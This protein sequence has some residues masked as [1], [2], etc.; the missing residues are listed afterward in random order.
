M[1]KIKHLLSKEDLDLI[2]PYL[3]FMVLDNE[4]KDYIKL[5]KSQFG[6]KRRRLWMFSSLLALIIILAL[7]FLLIQSVNLRKEAERNEDEAK[8]K[9]EEA[10]CLYLSSL[11]QEVFE[12]DPTRGLALANLALKN[13]TENV[14][15]IIRKIL[16]EMYYN[17]KSNKQF[18]FS[19]NIE[20][21]TSAIFFPD[22][23]MILTSSDDTIVKKWI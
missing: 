21:A 10:Q 1:Q 19:T 14:F 15:L 12:T 22:G 6:R 2:E 16:M 17:A 7:S 13:S 9:T 20:G 11:S 23:K 3:P 4:K 5:S 18:L 8:L